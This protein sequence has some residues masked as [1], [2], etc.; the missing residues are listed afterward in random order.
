MK[1]TLFLV[2]SLSFVFSAN[3]YY[4]ITNEYPGHIKITLLVTSILIGLY[5][6]VFALVSKIL[7]SNSKKYYFMVIFNIILSLVFLSFYRKMKYYFHSNHYIDHF[8]H[9]GDVSITP[10]LSLLVFGIPLYIL[11]V[12]FLGKKNNL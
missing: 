7:L 3:A 2:L 10:F 5:A 11:I 12:S 4:I 8:F 9:L 1:F 6:I